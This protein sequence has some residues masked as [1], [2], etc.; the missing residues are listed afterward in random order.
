MY[1]SRLMYISGVMC[2]NNAG[3]C[4]H[5]PIRHGT[6]CF[7]FFL[8]KER[9]NMAA[10]GGAYHGTKTANKKQK[11]KQ[12]TEDEGRKN[13]RKKVEGVVVVVGGRVVSTFTGR[14]KKATTT[15]FRNETNKQLNKQTTDS[16][17]AGNVTI[18]TVT[19]STIR[20]KGKRNKYMFLSNAAVDSLDPHF[21]KEV[22]PGFPSAYSQHSHC[23]DI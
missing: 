1:I 10:P 6:M 17:F 9:T 7:L 2:I 20:V 8:I 5:V 14:Q 12:K 18:Q 4:G 23:I 11:T 22:Q 13:V 21:S 15:L 19:A 3:M 16:P